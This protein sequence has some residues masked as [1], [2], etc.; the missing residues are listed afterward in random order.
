MITLTIGD[1]ELTIDGYRDMIT[2]E[3]TKSGDLELHFFERNPEGLWN[4]AKFLANNED[5]GVIH[6]IYHQI[7]IFKE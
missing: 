1:Y 7:E 2:I 6:G 5:F 4:A 3:D